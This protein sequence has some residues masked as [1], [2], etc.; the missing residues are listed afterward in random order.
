MFLA[1][2]TRFLTVALAVILVVGVGG[3]GVSEARQTDAVASLIVTVG[4]A[5]LTSGDQDP[6]ELTPDDFAE[7]HPDDLIAVPDGG[8]AI[9]TFFEGIETR[10]AAGTSLTV[11]VVQSEDAPDTMRLDVSAGQVFS[12]VETMADTQSRFEVLTPAAAISVRGTQFLVFVRQT[13]LTQVATLEGVVAVSAQDQTAELP[14]GFGL[15]VAPGQAPGAVSVWGQL[16]LAVTAPVDGVEQLPVTLVNADNG[17]AFYYHAGD[18]MTAVL[19]SYDVIVNSPGPYRTAVTFPQDTE[20]NTP[21]GLDV[22]LGALVINV[23]DDNEN[24]LDASGDLI[25]HLTQGDLAGQATVAPGETFAAGPG[26]WQL[27]IT[28]VAQ[29]NTTVSLNVDVSAGEV[30]RVLIPQSIFNVQT[31]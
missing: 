13:D 7:V 2:V 12:N 24:P 25:V 28:P 26:R 30:L 17:Q 27:E 31:K 15:K 4:S 23:V 20:A 11:E 19:G 3:G 21:V 10:I 29:P 18:L 22:A 16:T 14:T 5:T 1:H 6:Q 9:L 8:E